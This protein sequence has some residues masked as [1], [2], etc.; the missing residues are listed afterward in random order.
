M[1]LLWGYYGVT[2]GLLW[3]YYGVTM[4]LLWSYYGVLKYN[5]LLRI[6]KKFS[7]FIPNSLFI[8]L[9]LDLKFC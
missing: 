6:P 3:G 4:G 1:G 8:H 2:M 5:G 7:L 9:F